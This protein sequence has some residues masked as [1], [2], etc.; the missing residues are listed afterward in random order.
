MVD[1]GRIAAGVVPSGEGEASL[2]SY[3]KHFDLIR[4]A[5]LPLNGVRR[6]L[7]AT[8][9]GAAS[10]SIDEGSVGVAVLCWLV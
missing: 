4:H 2:R 3:A 5:L 9:S 8:T 1:A 10:R 7:R 6:I